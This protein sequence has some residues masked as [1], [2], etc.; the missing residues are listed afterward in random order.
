MTNTGSD[1]VS[2]IHGSKNTAPTE[3]PVGNRPEGI[4]VSGGTSA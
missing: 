3:I 2:V 4:A 1:S